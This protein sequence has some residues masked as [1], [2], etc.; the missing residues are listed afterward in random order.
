MLLSICPS[1]RAE[2]SLKFSSQ[3]TT[4]LAV[5]YCDRRILRRFFWVCETHPCGGFLSHGRSPS[6]HGFQWVLCSNDLDENWGYPNDLG[7]FYRLLVRHIQLKM[8]VASPRHSLYDLSCV[9]HPALAMKSSTRS[10]DVVTLLWRDQSVEWTW[11]FSKVSA[12]F[13]NVP[14]PKVRLAVSDVFRY[15]KCFIDWEVVV[16]CRSDR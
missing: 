1:A 9:G 13:G 5:S 2:L 8:S 11:P 7:N 10:V 6:H 3:C 12:T 14:L 15:A 16:L 4:S